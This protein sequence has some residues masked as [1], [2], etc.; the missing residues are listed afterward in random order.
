MIAIPTTMTAIDPEAP[1]GPEVLVPVDRPVPRLSEGEVLVRVAA[2][3]VNRPELMQREGK[4]PPPPGAPSIL[5]MELAGEVVALGA[6]VASIAIGDRVCALV[7]GG[8]YAGFAVA[9]APL[10]LPVPD[11]LSMIEAAAL[12]ET[13][14]TVWDNVFR[15]GRAA[16][17]ERLLVHGGTSGI[18]AMAILLGGLFGIEV[19][20]TAGSA[21]KC[22]AAREIGAAH[23]IDYKT[24]DF[25]AEVARI[26]A[27]RGV[28]VVLDMVGGDY[29]PRNLKCLADEGR[30]VSIAVQRG[31]KAELPIWEVMRRR[32]VLTGS[33]LRARDL[34][35]KAGLADD[36]RAKVWP[37]VADGRLR[38]VIDR[39]FPLAEAADAHRR[40]EQGAHVGK[41]VLTIA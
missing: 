22:A 14:F 38:P 8:S 9:P 41:V 37:M 36:I 3:G 33:T 28:D 27:G 29:L 1:G 31:A 32:L 13:L 26:T 24:Q 19:I 4:Y 30:H 16:A 39:T 5:G 10:C 12:P 34:A 2:A 18:G 17:G 20:A 23:A 6:G 21:A 25:V 7:A 35:F 40:L 11:D 15:R